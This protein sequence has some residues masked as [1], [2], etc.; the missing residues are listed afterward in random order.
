MGKKSI[1]AS[2][3]GINA[4]EK[5]NSLNGCIKDILNF[6]KLLRTLVQNQNDEMEYRPLYL[7][8]PK[9][10]DENIIKQYAE[11]ENITLQ[12]LLP[13]FSNVSG[14]AFE[15]LANAKNNDICIFYYSGHGS[16]LDAP[17]A[18]WSRQNTRVNQT[19]VCCDS[20]SAAR[21]LTN[22]E[23]GYLLYKTLKDKPDVHCLVI[24]DCC[25]SGSNTRSLLT[26]SSPVRFRQES[27]SGQRLTMQDYLGF[28][29][30]YY[31]IDADG[32]AN[33]EPASYISLSACRDNEKAMDDYSGGL[34]SETLTGYLNSGSKTE[35][36]RNIIQNLSST[37]AKRNG[38][39]NPVAFPDDKIDQPFLG[40]KLMPYT[41]SYEVRYLGGSGL[42]QLQAGALQGIVPSS[43]NQKTK[44]NILPLNIEAEVT[45]VQ[46]F[47]ATLTGSSLSKLDKENSFYKATIQQLAIKR[48]VVGISE[49]LKAKPK[50]VQLL[51]NAFDP[52]KHQY[53]ILD[54]EAKESSEYI[55]NI[56]EINKEM[57]FYLTQAVNDVPV[58]KAEADPLSFLNNADAVG[59]W[60]YVKSLKSGNSIFTSD[61]FIF[62]VEKVEGESSDLAIRNTL[63]GKPEPVKPGDQIDLQYKEDHSPMLRFSVKLT[64]G[65]GINECYVQ[66]VYFDSLFGIFTGFIEPDVSRLTA[67]G[68][69]RLRLKLRG[70]DYDLI[71]FILDKEYQAYNINEIVEHLKIIVSAQP[72][73]QIQ[74]FKQDALT[75]EFRKINQATRGFEKESDHQH[76]SGWAAFD[77]SLRIIGPQKQKQ[78]TP[79]GD[80]GFSTFTI[81]APADFHATALA[82]TPADAL[83]AGRSVS[84]AAPDL[85]GDAV[86]ESLPF[87]DE[88]GAHSGK[89]TI[90]VEITWEDNKKPPEVNAEKPLIITP[91]ISN[92]TRSV[93]D[94]DTVTIPYGYDE[95]TDLYF[96]VGYQDDAGKIYITTL[97]SPTAGSLVPEA[98]HTR[99]VLGS[100][101]L[102]FK[103][104]FKRQTNTLTLHIYRNDEW[105]TVTGITEIV[106]VL[107]KIKP[108]TLPFIIHGIFG[109]TKAIVEGLKLDDALAKDFPVMLSYDYE[110]LSTKIS[111]TAKELRKIFDKIGAGSDGIPRLTII[112]HSMG[113]LVSRWCIEKE[114]GDKYVEKFIM[115]GT[116]NSGSEWSAAGDKI[117]KGA[118]FLL[119]HAMNSIG[120]V[121]YAISGIGF[122][123][124]KFHDPQT[125][126]NDMGLDAD[127]IKKLNDSATA[128]HIDYYLVGSDTN[129]YREYSG[130]DHFLSKVKFWLMDKVVFPGLDQV[131]FK[132]L[133]ND[134]AVTVDSM[135]KIKTFDAEKNMKILPG[136]HISYFTE[137]PTRKTILTLLKN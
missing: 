107:K 128:A 67:T 14:K 126:L 45:D 41:P 2:L 40:G 83:R 95:A 131:L 68:E 115:A 4:Y 116:P 55:V 98:I 36:Y 69:I 8:S 72:N 118:G 43:G 135:K 9:T 65:S 112:A 77:F 29:E 39:Q 58:F 80:T 3:I 114:G 44:V 113:G 22:K 101:K 76:I 26:E 100:V 63:K 81:T 129:L 137:E 51:K 84:E 134:M 78:I 6:D 56:G 92:L 121:K 120:P 130:E 19:L 133:P 127:F 18:F 49:I 124:K 93:D 38:L 125:A 31:N 32:N 42:W 46:D 103:K 5:A 50:L 132:K 86:A 111:D 122:L 71:Q 1:Y 117:I 57:L 119:S 74:G 99:S 7:L 33:P 108:K 66:A 85:W 106:P 48:L 35:S 28:A 87:G 109:D 89:G 123:L 47:T 10:A 90:A 102:Y 21:D 52:V 54:T 12:Y 59:K 25:H 88:F 105:T 82:V 110:N 75:L 60:L 61:D 91:K 34:F 27:S 97:P 24:M 53:I 11:R 17:K 16:Y 136:D 94:N 15:H 62:T 30:G 20:R 96:P 37:I 73:V 104:L 13:T 64:P 79:G 23:I 70:K